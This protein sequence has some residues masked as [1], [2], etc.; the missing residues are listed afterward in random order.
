MINLW[1]ISMFLVLLK[2]VSRVELKNVCIIWI[3][4]QIRDIFRVYII[5]RVIPVNVTNLFF[6]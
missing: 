4:N 6:E 1:S 2:P 3:G 5:Y